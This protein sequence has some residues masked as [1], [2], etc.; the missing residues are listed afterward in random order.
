MG[1]IGLIDYLWFVKGLYRAL[2]V[3][4]DYKSSFINCKYNL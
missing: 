1:W 3:C 4:L 2:I